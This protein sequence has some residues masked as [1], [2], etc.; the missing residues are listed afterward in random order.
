MNGRK[1]QLPPTHK[2]ELLGE[3][4]RSETTRVERRKKKRFGLLFAMFFLM[5]GEGGGGVL[6][7]L[8]ALLSRACRTP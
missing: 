5:E 2:K 6:L 7:L 8:F 3:P 1:N 4:C